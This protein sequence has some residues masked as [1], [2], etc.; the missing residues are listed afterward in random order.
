MDQV[1]DNIQVEHVVFA[2]PIVPIAKPTQPIVVTTKSFQPVQ[3]V[4]EPMQIENP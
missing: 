4:V 3:L 2:K 1:I